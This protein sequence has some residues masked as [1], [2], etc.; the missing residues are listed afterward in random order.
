M[1]QVQQHFAMSVVCAQ[2]A[3]GTSSADSPGK[4]VFVCVCVCL[5]ASCHSVHGMTCWSLYEASA[6]LERW[7]SDSVVGQTCSARVVSDTW[8]FLRML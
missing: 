5:Q 3:L 7:C 1:L 6:Q 4:A 8:F 2:E